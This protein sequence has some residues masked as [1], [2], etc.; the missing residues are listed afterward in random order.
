MQEIQVKPTWKMA[1]VVLARHNFIAG[2][3]MLAVILL[4]TGIVA[5]VLYCQG[6]VVSLAA[7]HEILVKYQPAIVWVLLTIMLFPVNIYTVTKTIQHNYRGFRV[8]VYVTPQPL[9][10]ATMDNVSSPLRQNASDFD[11][12]F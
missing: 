11:D 7:L 12:Q 1:R 9:K 10:E 3:L 6:E 5:L 8:G 4:G 2:S